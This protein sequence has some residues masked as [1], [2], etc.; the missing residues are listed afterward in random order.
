M[1]A[2]WRGPI[3][4]GLI[5]GSGLFTYIPTALYYVYLVSCMASRAPAEGALLGACYGVSYSLAFIYGA[6]RFAKKRPESY[7]LS[8]QSINRRIGWIGAFAA[9]LACAAPFVHLL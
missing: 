8:G 4:F 3:A 7:L 1:R 6:G 9:P 2:Y 5:M